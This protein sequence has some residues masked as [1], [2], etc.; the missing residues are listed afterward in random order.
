LWTRPLGE[1]YSGIDVDNGVL[2]TM[3]RRGDQEV[4]AA[5][6]AKTGK[7]IWEHP[8]DAK[9]RSGMGMENGLGPHSTPLVVGDRVFTVGILAHLFAFQK[10]TGK[11]LWEK[12]LYKD[13]PGSTSMDRGYACSPLAYKDNI[14]LS[15]GGAGHAVIALKQSDGALVWG[16]EQDYRNA[17]GSPVLIK[18]DGQ[19]QV[20]TFLNEKARG[21]VAGVVAGLDPNNGKILWTHPHPTNWGLNIAL[22]VWGEDH[23]LFVSCAYSGGAR[24]LQLTKQGDKTIVKEL[25][26]NNNL[27]IHHGTMTRVGDLVF[28]SSGDFGPAP[29]TAINIKTGELKWRERGFPKANFLHVDGKFI[30]LDEDGNLSLT[31]LSGEGVKVLSKTKLLE[32]N[33]W[34][35]PS[36]AGKNLYV[37]DR[38]SIMAVELP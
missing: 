9:I 23:I 30:I 5:L 36:L 33:A 34:T 3:Y 27:R 32:R 7:T 10:K 25:W 24:A 21:D 1:G 19:D 22:P 16:T 4:A 12:D 18:L 13:F 6:D 20:V 31:Q 2:Y 17:P 15:L 28:G 11:I 8:Y 14:I 38:R 37:R 35:A 26:H 29:L